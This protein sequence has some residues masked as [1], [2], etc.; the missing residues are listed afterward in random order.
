MGFGATS[1]NRQDSSYWYSARAIDD[2]LADDSCSD[3]MKRYLFSCVGK[4]QF[5]NPLGESKTFR[6]TVA[7]RA[8]KGTPTKIQ[9]ALTTPGTV[10]EAHLWKLYLIRLYHLLRNR[11]GMAS[12]L[13]S[14]CV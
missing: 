14:R 8:P 5:E 7:M 1:P 12:K 10:V 11:Q 6:S 2:I 4:K 9:T 13:P 3:Y